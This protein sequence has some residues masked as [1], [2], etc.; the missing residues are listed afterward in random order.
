M[1]DIQAAVGCVQVKK[2]DQI[3]E[4]KR[5][6]ALRYDRLLK[7]RVPEL[8]PPAVPEGYFHTYQSYVCM[9]DLKA[10]GIGSVEEGGAFR[11]GWRIRESRQGRERTPCICWAITGILTVTGRRII[12]TRTPATICPLPFRTTCSLLKRIRTG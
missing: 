7:E 9:L 8:I 12:R 1:T 2:L 10:L 3:I 6:N 11:S 5:K 4:I